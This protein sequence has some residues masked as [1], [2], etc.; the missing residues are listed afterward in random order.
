MLIVCMLVCCNRNA[1]SENEVNTSA[2]IKQAENKYPNS[3]NTKTLH[4]F[5]RTHNDTTTTLRT[6]NK[7]KTRR[8]TDN[9]IKRE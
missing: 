7:K 2:P 9:N 6:K 3:D 5:N 4:F 8:K 1:T